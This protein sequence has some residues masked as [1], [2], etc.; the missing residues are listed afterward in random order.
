MKPLQKIAKTAFA[1]ILFAGLAAPAV[2]ETSFGG[3]KPPTG[4]L[5]PPLDP[6]SVDLTTRKLAPGVYALLST[7]PP[8]DNG[9]FIVG[10]R[11]VLVIDDHIN[12]TGVN[13]LIGPNDERLG[14]RF[15]DMTEAWDSKARDLADQ[16]AAEVGINL[17]HGVYM[18][19]QG[20]LFETPAEIRSMRILGAD[21]VGMSTVPECIAARHSGM[22]VLGISCITNLAAGME[23]TTLS[24]DH[25]LSEGAKAAM[26][27]DGAMPPDIDYDWYIKE[28]EEILI[29]VGH[30]P[31][32]ESQVA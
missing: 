14:V 23:E 11:G 32:L 20:P 1:A 29:S 30:T 8:V 26:E 17:Y 9:G 25:T 3:Y 22:K 24:H 7:R 12:L 6:T 2:A 16:A 27:L 28:A 5:P 18:L 31:V 4:W 15:L 10:S 13:P 21:A 19:W